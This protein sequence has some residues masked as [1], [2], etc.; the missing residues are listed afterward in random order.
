LFSVVGSRW[1][2]KEGHNSLGVTIVFSEVDL[3]FEI[4]SVV[5][6]IQDVLSLFTEK[7]EIGGV[8]DSIVAEF[9]LIVDNSWGTIFGLRVLKLADN[10]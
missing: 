8:F 2:N 1:V 7:D 9:L 6:I 3:H 5:L 10:A 4:G